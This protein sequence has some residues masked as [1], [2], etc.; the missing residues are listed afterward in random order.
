MQEARALSA[1]SHYADDISLKM[2]IYYFIILNECRRALREFKKQMPPAKFTYVEAVA[3]LDD[4]MA[5]YFVLYFA[6]TPAAI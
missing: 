1:R 3:R 5:T 2:I 4:E 6:Y